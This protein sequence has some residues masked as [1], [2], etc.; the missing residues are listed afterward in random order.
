M[1]ETI[2]KY[3]L[4]FVLPSVIVFAVATAVALWRKENPFKTFIK[5]MAWLAS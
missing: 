4:A 3:A 5:F 2:G 1:L